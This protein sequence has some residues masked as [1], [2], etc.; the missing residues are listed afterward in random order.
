[1]TS[2]KT[3]LIL[4]AE[5]VTRLDE[6]AGA[7]GISRAEVIRRAILVYQDRRDPDQAGEDSGPVLAERNRPAVPLGVRD[8]AILT[9]GAVLYLG[10]GVMAAAIT[11]VLR[12]GER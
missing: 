1:M 4:P 9:A 2:I 8:R 5:M 11:R 10:F 7:A 12:S 6:E 3:S